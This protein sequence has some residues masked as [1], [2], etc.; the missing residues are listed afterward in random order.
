MVTRDYID[1]LLPRNRETWAVVQEHS[2]NI[3]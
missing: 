3:L 2:L 1:D